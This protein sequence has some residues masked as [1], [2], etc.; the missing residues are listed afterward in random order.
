MK[1]ARKATKDTI[2]KTDLTVDD[3]LTSLSDDEFTPPPS[4]DVI[5]LIKQRRAVFAS[6]VTDK[7]SQTLTIG[8]SLI[9]DSFIL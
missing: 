4:P 1:R 9:D 2:H 5:D 3:I 7:P 6:Q 8:M